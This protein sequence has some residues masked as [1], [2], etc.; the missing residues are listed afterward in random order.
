MGATIF[1]YH[2]E[3][4]H[5]FDRFAR[6]QGRLDWTTQP[7]PFRYYLGAPVFDLLHRSAW[8]DVPYGALYE[9]ESLGRAVVNAAT[10][11]DFLRH[12]LGLSA[13]KHGA[14]ERWSLRVNP[15]S[16]NLHPTEC[17]LVTGP[18]DGWSSRGGVYHYVSETHTLEA[19]CRF[20]AATL[21]AALD[22]QPS[23]TFLVALTSIP[24]R[25]A[26]KYGER[27]FRYCLHDA[28][29]ALAALSLSAALLGWRLEIIPGWSH[30]AIAKM[31]GLDRDADFLLAER[32]EV[33]CIAVV[34][35][36]SD[37]GDPPSEPVGLAAAIASGDWAGRANR[38]SLDHVKWTWID[39]AAEATRN[40][41]TDVSRWRPATPRAVRP[42]LPSDRTSARRIALQRRSAVDFDGVSSMPRGDF[43]RLLERLLPCATPPWNALWWPPMVHLAIFVHRVAGL[44]PGVYMLVRRPE[45]V[46]PLRTATDDEFCWQ[47]VRGFAERL[48]LFMLFEGDCRSL[49]MRLSCDQ[50]IAGASFFSLGMIAEFAAPIERYGPWFYRNLFWE[51]GTIGQ[52]LYLEA[53]AAGARGTGIGCYYDEP[54]HHLFGFD[55][56]HDN[57][58]RPAYQSLYHFTIGKPL[59]D[60]RLRTLPGY[61]EERTETG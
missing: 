53:E 15:S 28:G 13:W 61:A 39:A 27:A 5:H 22:G 7:H 33:E 18:I 1:R 11:G 26:W 4:K 10:I 59:E 31:L 57:S 55:E 44:E 42:L 6:S 12:A 30:R 51:A 25:E 29:H 37:G 20:P 47:P 2:E 48:P 43:E 32:E 40:P 50:H 34:R 54:V 23:G 8:P 14:G 38:L 9:P 45:A 46:A 35:P 60:R 56:P 36:G 21:Q 58:D 19:R 41:G 52:V 17:Y 24:W 16:G 49:A 3:T